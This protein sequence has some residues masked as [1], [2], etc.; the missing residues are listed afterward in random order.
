[1]KVLECMTLV[2]KSLAKEKKPA[3]FLVDYSGSHRKDAKT[4]MGL[5]K[6]FPSRAEEVAKRMALKKPHIYRALGESVYEKS[7]MKV[8]EQ[9][10]TVPKTVDLLYAGDPSQN[11]SGICCTFMA[12]FPVLEE[13]KKRGANLI[14]THEPTFYSGD[15]QTGWLKDDPVYQKKERWLKE[16]NMAV[17]RLHDMLHLFQPDMIVQG[18][19]SKLGWTENAAFDTANNVVVSFEDGAYPKESLSADLREKLGCQ[20]IRT[21]GNM[22]GNVRKV[23]LMVGASGGKPQIALA[24]AYDLDALVCGEIHEWE[25]AAYVGDAHHAGKEIAL[26]VIGHQESETAGME[27]LTDWLKEKLAG[28]DIPVSYIDSK[29]LLKIENN[30]RGENL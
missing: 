20:V 8:L 24:G 11:V 3:N 13:A 22:R 28:L 9:E 15:D 6:N 2:L 16:N 10:G 23:G 21:T 4:A 26:Y 14:I 30:N 5:L 29:P 19:L 17:W 27:Y 12:T 25:T 1:M 7:V 18:T